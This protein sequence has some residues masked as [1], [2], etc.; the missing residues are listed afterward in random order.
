MHQGACSDRQEQIAVADCFVGGT[1]G[2]TW[3]GLAKPDNPGSLRAAAIAS[4]GIVRKWGRPILFFQS[5]Q[6]ATENPECAVQLDDPLAA[7]FDENHR[8]I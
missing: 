2:A 1:D 6:R 4:R 8:T 3:Q 7:G 5:A